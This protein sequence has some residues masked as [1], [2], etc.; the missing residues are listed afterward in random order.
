MAV[1]V[2]S[3][4]EQLLPRL[5][6][7]PSVRS[8]PRI[9]VVAIAVVALLGIFGTVALQ[10]M[11]ATAAVE[12]TTLE[13]K[14]RASEE[15]YLL[16]RSKVATLESPD[17]ISAAAVAKGLVA[18]PDPQFITAPDGV[19]TLTDSEPLPA[20]RTKQLIGSQW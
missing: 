2:P 3:L 4:R 19:K 6:S 17:R 10:A 12:L 16:L 8:I 5:R 11:L 20:S 13:S 1:A 7:L 18:D 9:H 15:E 14:I